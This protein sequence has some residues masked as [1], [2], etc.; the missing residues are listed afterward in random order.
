MPYR[1]CTRVST[2]IALQHNRSHIRSRGWSQQGGDG[3]EA[4][5]PWQPFCQAGMLL[6]E[7]RPYGVEIGPSS[8]NGLKFPY[9]LQKL[10]AMQPGTFGKVEQVLIDVEQSPGSGLM[11]FR[12]G[13][14]KDGWTAIFQQRYLPP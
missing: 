8:P 3:D 13:L 7:L 10:L 4:A 9:H 5:P 14:H 2:G 11:L 12:Q 6:G 1:K